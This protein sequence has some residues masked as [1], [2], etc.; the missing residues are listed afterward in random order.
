[1]QHHP[2]GILR[3]SSGAA[4][5]TWATGIVN[6]LLEWLQSFRTWIDIAVLVRVRT[7]HYIRVRCGSLVL[8][9]PA[10]GVT[11]DSLLLCNLQVLLR[12]GPRGWVGQKNTRTF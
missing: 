2:P 5:P 1:M 11:S 4:L 3:C 7:K 6:E 8:A 9:N 10:D 12:I